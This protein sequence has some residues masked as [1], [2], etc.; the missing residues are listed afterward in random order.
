MLSNATVRLARRCATSNSAEDWEEL[1]RLLTPEIALAAHRVCSLWGEASYSTVKEITQEVFLKLCEDDRRVLREFED[2]GNHSFLKLL[3]KITASVATDFM[4]H[5]RAEKRGGNVQ[6]IA[7]EPRMIT[8]QVWD[9]GAT[10]AVEWPTLIAQLDGILRFHRESVSMR[11]RRLFWLYFRQGLTAEAIARIP[12]IGLTSKGVE[13]ALIR[14]TRLLRK[15]IVEGR[16]IRN[17][18]DLKK[19][20]VSAAPAKG[21]PRVIAIDSMKH[22]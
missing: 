9:D 2:R 6:M 1:V 17:G 16:Q 18:T 12:S 13:S 19:I 14:L 4:R 22:R 20:P 21:F 10:E 11:D 3:R 15:A 5:N 8:D 7:L